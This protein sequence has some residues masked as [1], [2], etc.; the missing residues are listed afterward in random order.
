MLGAVAEWAGRVNG[1]RAV[2]HRSDA[3]AMAGNTASRAVP[4]PALSVVV[5]GPALFLDQCGFRRR[6][7]EVVPAPK[8]LTRLRRIEPPL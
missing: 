6:W 8:I 4:F 3:E 1:S 7:P 5:R 2:N